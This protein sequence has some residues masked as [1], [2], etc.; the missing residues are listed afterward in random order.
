[1]IRK[2]TI[3]ASLL[4]TSLTA[5]SVEAQPKFTA[6][7]IWSISGTP[8]GTERELNP[9]ATLTERN[10]FVGGSIQTGDSRRQVIQVFDPA[11]G[12]HRR[13]IEDVTGEVFAGHGEQIVANDRFVVTSTYRPTAAGSGSLQVYDA[14]TGA[15]LRT[16]TNPRAK[17][18]LAF[19]QLQISL[20]GSRILAGVG[21]SKKSSENNLSTS[22]VFD[23]ETGE[24][25]MTVDE[26]D[27]DA[28]ILTKE[29]PTFFGFANA[30]TDTH[31]LISANQKQIGE[32]LGAGSAYLFDAETGD[33]LQTFRPE[34]PEHRKMFGSQVAMNE[35]IALI[36]ALGET[37]P[38]GWTSTEITA[39]DLQTGRLLYTLLDPFVPQTNEEVLA[40]YNG[41]GFGSNF[42]LWNDILIIGAPETSGAS[43]DTGALLF[44]DATTGERLWGMF[45]EDGI[46]GENFGYTTAVHGDLMVAISAPEIELFTEITRIDAFRLELK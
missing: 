15:H 8:I 33:L 29:P 5:V 42:T 24:V 30:L 41:S 40:G 32:K 6:E 3:L 35:D 37:G 25:I 36:S 43:K 26:P 27:N 44:Y 19:G 12:R 4:L 10:L 9:Y 18:S 17:D 28:G 2:F 21:L 16:I 1:M 22:W 46:D 11:T 23:A 7:P 20:E 31:I 45:N 34:R 14:N 39:Y 38:L 13:T